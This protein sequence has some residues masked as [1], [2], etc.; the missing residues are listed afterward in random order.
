M[1]SQYRSIDAPVCVQNNHRSSI[2]PTI[3]TVFYAYIVH[4]IN[5]M[6]SV[7]SHSFSSFHRNVMSFSYSVSFFKTHIHAFRLF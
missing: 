5:L 1:L 7:F 6:Q 4:C 2:L 3:P